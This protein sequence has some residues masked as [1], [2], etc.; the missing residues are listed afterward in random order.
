MLVSNY[1][2]NK[3]G[4]KLCL[5]PLLFITDAPFIFMKLMLSNSAIVQ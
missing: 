2:I 4:F 1:V 3:R 5:K